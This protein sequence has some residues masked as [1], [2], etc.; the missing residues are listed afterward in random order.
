MKTTEYEA[1]HRVET[2]GAPILAPNYS[3]TVLVAEI[4]SDHHEHSI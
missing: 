4:C 1:K 2:Y 3:A